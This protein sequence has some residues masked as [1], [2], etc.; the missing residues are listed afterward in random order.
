MSDATDLARRWGA[1]WAAS[2]GMRVERRGVWP[3]LHVRA[4]SRATEL[5]AVDPRL[6]DLA[7]IAAFI[8][9]DPRAMA[10]ILTAD[11][12]PFRAAPLPDGVRVERDDETFMSTRLAATG[13]PLPPGYHARWTAED[14]RMRYAVEREGSC[15]AEGHV[16]VLGDVAVLDGVETSAAHRHRGL[17]SHVTDAMTG[18]AASE[19]ASTG[20]LAASPEGRGLY[21]SLGWEPLLAMWSLMGVGRKA[22]P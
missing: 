11:L 21:E 6:G 13:L 8:A 19:G 7:A 10:T 3:L 22:H 15:V 9:G 5:I 12:A 4:A 16:G 2:R 1:A 20:V 18:W 14:R 17:G